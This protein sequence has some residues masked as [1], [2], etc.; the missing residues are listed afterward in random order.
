MGIKEILLITHHRDP[1]II[2]SHHIL[3]QNGDT[4]N[5]HEIALVLLEF[6]NDVLCQIGKGDKHH[7]VYLLPI[8]GITD[9]QSPEYYPKDIVKDKR[10]KEGKTDYVT[11][12]QIA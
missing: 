11:G 9:E 2:P 1:V 6:S 8:P 10:E 12:N 7:I 5:T 4:G 3:I